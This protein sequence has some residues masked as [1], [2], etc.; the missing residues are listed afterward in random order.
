MTRKY[1]YYGNYKKNII[2]VENYKKCY[3]IT[4]IFYLCIF[5]NNVVY[6][7]LKKNK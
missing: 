7:Y 6:K 2:V 5:L 4:M 3:N 1:H